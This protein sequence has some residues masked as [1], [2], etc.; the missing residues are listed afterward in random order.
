MGHS[1]R[2]STP[3]HSSKVLFAALSSSLPLSVLLSLSL[4]LCPSLSVPLSSPC[5]LP[6]M[7]PLSGPSPLPVL[8]ALLPSLLPSLYAIALLPPT[9]SLCYQLY[10]TSSLSVLPLPPTLSLPLSLCYTLSLLYSLSTF[11]LFY[12]IALSVS[13]SLSP[14]PL[15][16]CYSALSLSLSLPSSPHAHMAQHHLRHPP[17]GEH[18]LSPLPL[19][20]IRLPSPPPS[21]GDPHYPAP[22]G[23]R[24]PL[25]RA[26]SARD[27][28]GFRRKSLRSDADWTAPID[29]PSRAQSNALRAVRFHLEFS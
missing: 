17:S 8:Q 24:A 18:F 4:S 29:P 2:H 6:P 1:T 22:P 3:G 23:I 20:L 14:Y 13:L 9:L 16:L 21:D 7:V 11:S 28:A 15:S 10:A 19:R 5:S 25:K 12:A 27:G 26:I